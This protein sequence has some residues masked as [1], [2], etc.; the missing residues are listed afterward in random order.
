MEVGNPG[1][2]EPT[3]WVSIPSHT[4]KT[5]FFFDLGNDMLLGLPHYRYDMICLTI[6]YH[7][8]WKLIYMHK[9]L[10]HF[11]QHMGYIMTLTA[12]YYVMIDGHQLQ[13]YT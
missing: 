10:G 6:F 5:V 4:K 9:V 1:C 13:S 12:T 7:Q 3:I 2:H 11:H 8:T